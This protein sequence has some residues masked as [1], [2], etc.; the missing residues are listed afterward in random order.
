MALYGRGL[1]CVRS[2]VRYLCPGPHKASAKHKGVKAVPGNRALGRSFYRSA[3][4]VPED[5]A[6]KYAPFGHDRSLRQA[7]AHRTAFANYAWNVAQAFVKTGCLPMGPRLHSS[8]TADL[9]LTVSFSKLSALHWGCVITSLLPTT[10]RQTDKSKG[11]IGHRRRR[12]A[13]TS[14]DHPTQ[15]DPLL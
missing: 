12:S 10:L 13:I 3:W 5:S 9:R 4:A 15:W 6:R 1:L 14:P 7:R 2:L 11:L 8:L